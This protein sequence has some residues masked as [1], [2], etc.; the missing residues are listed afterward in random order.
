LVHEAAFKT[1]F[2]PLELR[3]VGIESVSARRLSG[4][5]ELVRI[6][7]GFAGQE[8]V[9]ELGVVEVPKVLGF[10]VVDELKIEFLHFGVDLGGV[11]VKVATVEDILVVEPLLVF[12]A[13]VN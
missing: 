10:V 5:L 4:D 6:D 13:V 12:E 3:L 7:G 11:V 8:G 2:R 1:R 9:V